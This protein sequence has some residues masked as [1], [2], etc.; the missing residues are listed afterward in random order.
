MELTSPKDDPPA[1]RWD[2]AQPG[3]PEYL[4]GSSPYLAFWLDLLAETGKADPIERTDG[5]RAEAEAGSLNALIEGSFGEWS[6]R[7]C[8]RRSSRFCAIPPDC[9]PGC[10]R[11][12]DRQLQNR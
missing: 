12:T 7:C 2:A 6:R 5:G 9:W 8:S 10:S 1:A 11:Q 4:P 3:F